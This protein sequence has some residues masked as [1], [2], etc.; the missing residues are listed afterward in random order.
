VKAEGGVEAE[1]GR[2]TVGKYVCQVSK[3]ERYTLHH[4]VKFSWDRRRSDKESENMQLSGVIVLPIAPSESSIPQ[5][6]IPFRLFREKMHK[7]I[8]LQQKRL[9][10]PN[11][12]QNQTAIQQ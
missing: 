3:W 4:Q 10:A 1:V 12:S 6:S 7:R 9:P 11:K 2:D 8:N 5:Q